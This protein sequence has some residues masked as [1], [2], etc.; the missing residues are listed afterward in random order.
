MSPR[1]ITPIL[2]KTGVNASRQLSLQCQSAQWGKLIS[3]LLIQMSCIHLEM[4]SPPFPLLHSS[5]KVIILEIIIISHLSANIH[6]ILSLAQAYT[7]HFCS[8]ISNLDLNRRSVSQDFGDCWGSPFSLFF[9][10]AI[11]V[12]FDLVASGSSFFT[13]L[14][15]VLNIFQLDFSCK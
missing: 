2:C 9:H 13:D 4:L 10:F 11:S 15:G 14:F 7:C 6:F 5:S 3:S 1:L 12:Y 8:T